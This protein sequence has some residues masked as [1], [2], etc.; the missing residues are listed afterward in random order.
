MKHLLNTLYVTTQGA[1]LSK[2]GETILVRLEHENRLRIPIHTLSGVGLLRSGLLQ[3]A[4]Y[5]LLRREQRC[6]Q[7][8]YRAW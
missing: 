3:S 7:L 8:S 6:A 5:G 1:Y 4:A 2:E